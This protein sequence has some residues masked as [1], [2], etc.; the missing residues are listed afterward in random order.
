MSLIASLLGQITTGTSIGGTTLSPDSNQVSNQLSRNATDLLKLLKEYFKDNPKLVEKDGKIGFDVSGLTKDQ[1]TEFQTTLQNTL[2]DQYGGALQLSLGDDGVL[3]IDTTGLSDKDKQTLTA[4][5]ENLNTVGSTLTSVQKAEVSAAITSLLNSGSLFIDAGGTAPIGGTSGSSSGQIPIPPPSVPT[6]TPAE[7]A[8]LA[9]KL[10][11]ESGANTINS[12]QVTN[13]ALGEIQ[14]DQAKQLMDQIIEVV[15]QQQDA[16]E[17]TAISKIFGW[18]INSILAVL[19]VVLIVAGALTS[20]IGVGVGLIIAGVGLLTGAAIGFV[21]TSPAGDELISALTTS[22]EN[23]GADKTTAS[24]LAV[25]ILVVIQFVVTFGFALIAAPFTGG[26][27]IAAPVAEA[28]T[29]GAEAGLEGAEVGIEVA[30]AAVTLGSRISQIA[31][32][33]ADFVQFTVKLLGIVSAGVNV[34]I[35]VSQGIVGLNIAKD[36]KTY[37][38]SLAKSK[39]VTNTLNQL[40]RSLQTTL[41]DINTSIGNSSSVIA[42]APTIASSGS[43]A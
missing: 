14:A 42:Q 23:D 20:E 33:I 40:I 18:V 25:V 15:K 27:S 35:G 3:G 21:L 34:T 36:E 8:F 5:F 28:V 10:L 13:T 7:Y 12:V 41:D 39:Q 22:L 4:L 16:A 2:D 31:V 17:K 30:G 37:L 43:H 32:Q 38:V 24:I 11:Y 26:A 6:P 1:V 19:A 29:A 9:G